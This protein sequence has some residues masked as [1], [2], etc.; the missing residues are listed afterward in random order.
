MNGVLIRPSGP[1]GPL[2]IIV[3][4]GDPRA[5]LPKILAANAF[6]ITLPASHAILLDI[7]DNPTDG[8]SWEIKNEDVVPHAID[9]DCQKALA[10]LS[11]RFKRGKY[12]PPKITKLTP[13]GEYVSIGSTEI[14]LSAG[15]KYCAKTA[16][17]KGFQTALYQPS[18]DSFLISSATSDMYHAVLVGEEAF[19]LLKLG[20]DSPKFKSQYYHSPLTGNYCDNGFVAKAGRFPGLLPNALRLKLMQ[21]VKPI[22][23]SRK[24]LKATESDFCPVISSF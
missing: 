23:D 6:P 9:F 14:K 21:I 10:L 19:D 7:N 20:T 4:E 22:V 17:P 2:A 8:L 16:L 12:T 15:Y 18:T 13:H 11:D 5:D 3:D 24:V 1:T